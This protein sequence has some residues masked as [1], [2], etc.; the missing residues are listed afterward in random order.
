V[1][2]P[3]RVAFEGLWKEKWI[4][5]L[6]M[7]TIG[8]GLFIMMLAALVVYN[9]NLATRSLPERFTITAYLK[10]GL[11]DGAT[12]DVMKAVRGLSGVKKVVYVSKDDA[13]RD[14]AS[15]LKD[16]DFV[17]E[18]LDENPLPDAL[19][20]T[21]GEEAVKGGRVG[22]LAATLSGLQGVQDVQYGEELLAAIRSVGR[23][24]RAFGLFLVT[25]LSAG[26]LFVC[27]STVKI[28]FY[29]KKPEIDTL[30]LL[31]ATRWFIRSPFLIEGGVVGLAGGAISGLSVAVLYSV[32]L[33][34]LGASLPAVL[35]IATPSELV[36]LAPP[37]GLL[38]GLV[39]AFFAVGRI[40]F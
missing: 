36:L 4:N 31:G 37:A 22:D 15:T 17:L 3:F 11:D 40:K 39:G 30:K 10:D 23:Y 1:S 16:A 21:L 7:C 27:Y 32:V 28:L 13:L 34:S 33:G 20:L 35:S 26:V 5:V 14:L 2:Y 18:G 19:V 25:V 24:S 8:A 6:S 38:V 12:G 9:L 29:R